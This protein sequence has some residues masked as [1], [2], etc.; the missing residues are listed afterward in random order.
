MLLLFLIGMNNTRE[1]LSTSH[2]LLGKPVVRWTLWTV[3]ALTLL[4]NSIVLY[5]R[6]FNDISEENK[7][8]I[9]FIIKNLAGKNLKNIKTKCVE[10]HYCYNYVH[11]N[12]YLCLCVYVLYIP[13]STL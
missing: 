12:K 5:D 4:M 7:I 6:I 9:N 3:S 13:A 10:K 8:G 11:V 2:S 1:D